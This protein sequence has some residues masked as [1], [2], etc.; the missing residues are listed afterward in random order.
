V[1]LLAVEL[2]RL[3]SRRLVRVIAVLVLAGIAVGATVTFLRASS[4]PPPR[5]TAGPAEA[6]EI[7]RCVTDLSDQLGPDAASSECETIVLGPARDRRFRLTALRDIA[8]V[9]SA[10]LLLLGWV[11]GASAIGAEWHAGTVTTLLTW[12]PRRVR[13]LLAK[14]LAAALVC[15]AGAVLVQAL[16]GAALLPSAL[17][18]GTTQGADAEWLRS[19]LAIV[20]RGAAM[21]SF[22]AVL[23]FAIA[24]VARNTA[25]AL[26]FGFVVTS[27]V[28][29]LVRAYRPNWGRWMLT[30]NIGIV[31]SGQAASVQPTGRGVL[32]AATV[33]LLYAAV[34]VAIAVTLFRARD[35]T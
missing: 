27:I 7:E 19:T 20:A 21:S 24:S 5:R 2:R 23:G 26:G 29:P 10:A 28:E 4:A 9:V 11:I 8:V 14:G 34:A 22:G 30:D 1:T 3:L 25:A 17:W 32:D 6:R 33:L 15:A 18:R 13:L 31:V 35:V 12:E 16:L